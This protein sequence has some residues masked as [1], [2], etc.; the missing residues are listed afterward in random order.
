MREVAIVPVTLTTKSGE[1]T[2]SATVTAAYTTAGS[3]STM[4]ERLATR[5]GIHKAGYAVLSGMGSA[6]QGEVLSDKAV[7]IS[8][9]I[10]LQGIDTVQEFFMAFLIIPNPSKELVLAGDWTEKVQ[11]L[12]PNLSWHGGRD[13]HTYRADTLM[14]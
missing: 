8:Y 6:M 9:S 2:R 13:A 4:S 12:N 11:A 3:K 10:S 14:S 5:L 1:D 7:K